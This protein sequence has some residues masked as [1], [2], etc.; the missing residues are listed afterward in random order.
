MI[1]KQSIKEESPFFLLQATA[2]R[3]VHRSRTGSDRTGVR[4]RPAWTEDRKG[5]VP[6]TEDRIGPVKD[7]PGQHSYCKI[8]RNLARC[9]RAAY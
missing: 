7:R 5:G 3:G 8:A 1:F 9:G 6:W 2:P 4:S